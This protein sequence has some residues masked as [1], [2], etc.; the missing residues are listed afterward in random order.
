[1]DSRAFNERTLG[2]S[3]VTPEDISKAVPD[4]NDAP[5]AGLLMYRNSH[6]VIRDNFADN[7]STTIGIVGP[8]SMAEQ[9]QTFIHKVTGSERP[10]GWDYQLKDEPVFMLSR[11]SIWRNPLAGNWFDAITIAHAKGGNLESAVGVGGIVR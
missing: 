4:P 2:Q 8:S 10:M 1:E 3:M 6:I 11:T 5:Y 7:V 9:A